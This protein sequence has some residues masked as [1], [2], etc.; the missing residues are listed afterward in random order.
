VLDVTPSTLEFG[1]EGCNEEGRCAWVVKTV[2]TFKE[3]SKGLTL[4]TRQQF[5]I[6]MLGKGALF[7][8]F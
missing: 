1:V 4:A 5:G 6:D 3:T 2:H 7:S 8:F